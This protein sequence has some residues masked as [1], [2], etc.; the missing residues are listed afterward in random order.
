M[1]EE[2]IKKLMD[3]I[4]DILYKKNNS[5]LCYQ[6]I[7]CRKIVHKYSN[8]KDPLYRILIDDKIINRNNPYRVSYKCIKCNSI[9]VVNLNNLV[10]KAQLIFFSN[11]KKK[12]SF[13]KF[14]K[15]NKSIRTDRLFKKVH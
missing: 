12:H 8:T 2:N 1:N 10:G 14:W 13:F 5:K 9:N 11:N 3:N 4:I 15:W 7:K 6:T